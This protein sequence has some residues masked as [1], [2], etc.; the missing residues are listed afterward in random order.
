MRALGPPE[1]L[2]FSVVYQALQTGVVGRHR[3]P[4]SNLYT[5]MMHV[6]QRLP[7]L[8]DS[9]GFTSATRSS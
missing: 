2:A 1:V 4:P 5:Q 8:S 3:V 9:Y 7:P 6:V